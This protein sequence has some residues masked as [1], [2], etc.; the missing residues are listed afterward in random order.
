MMRI[1]AVVTVLGFACVLAAAPPTHAGGFT[2]VLDTP[3]SMSPLA[4]RTLLVAVTR[5]G[6]RLVAVGQRGH[7]LTSDDGGTT[8]KQSTV[9]VSSDLTAVF[10]IDKDV[11][12][13]AGHDGV[14]LRSDD[15]GVRW[16]LQLEGRKANELLLAAMESAVAA[17]PESDSAKTLLAEAQRFKEQGPDKPFLDVWF[18]D[19]MN[20]FAVGA[21][22][23]IFAT[24]DGGTS[25]VPWFDRTENPKLYNL[26]ALRPV[27]GELWIVGEAG[28]VLRLDRGQQ[29][30][31]A[32]PTPYEG[33]YF[34]IADAGGAVLAYGLR[35]T[36]YRSADQG[37]SWTKIDARLPATI[38][39]SIRAGDGAALLLADAGGRIASSADGG[40]SWNTVALEQP[41]P[42]TGLADA[43]G[44]RIVLVGPRGAAVTRTGTP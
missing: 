29:R 1:P 15:G 11:G 17:Q 3:A 33:S 7:I 12:W 26:H 6:D 39:A 20:G 5:A 25:W 30:F 40:Q 21:Y 18:A 16:N 28:V 44:G 31:V 32:V 34:G 14:I 37:A 35:G 27:S 8:W 41:M 19:R 38:V 4:S 43:G 10:F 42:L 22:N 13:A 36:V 24:S 9:P 2:D 23:L